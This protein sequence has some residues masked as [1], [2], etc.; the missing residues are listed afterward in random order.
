MNGFRV[1][2][3]YP[4]L[5]QMSLVPPSICLL[6]QILKDHDITVELFDTTYYTIEGFSGDSDVSNQTDL[7]TRPYDAEDIIQLKQSN[8]YEDL[9]CKVKEFDPHLI[10]VSV[11]ESTFMLSISLLREI[12]QYNVLTIAGGVFPTFAPERAIRFPE[13]DIICV[14]EGE[15]SLVDLCER[16]RRGEDYSNVTNLWIKQNDGQVLRNP[17]AK[18]VNIDDNPIPDVG[19]FEKRRH[20]RA[21]AGNIYLMMAIETHR[22]CPFKCGYCNSPAQNRLYRNSTNCNFLRKR[23]MDRIHEEL[24]QY[25]DIWNAEYIFF[26]ADT[27]FTYSDQEI[28]EF[29]EMY[30]DIRLPFY[31]NAHPKT[32][33]DYKVKRLKEAGMHRMGVGIEHGNEKFRRE[34]VNRSYSNQEAI[35]ALKIPKRYDVK[36]SVNNIIGFPDE[37]YELA[38]DT[39]E[40]NR[41]IP[42][43]DH[44]CSIFQPYYGTALRELAVKRGYLDADFIAP[45]NT[46]GSVLT[47]PSFPKDRIQG[48][49]RTFVMYTRFPRSR[50]NEIKMAEQLTSEGDAMWTK[51]RDEFVENYFN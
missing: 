19:I 7:V 10:A 40:L 16:L 36:F 6:S 31:C 46:E 8:V 13:I 3:L 28:D 22:G 14:G 43:S 27:F 35:E 44:S 4:N 25:R 49:R 30:S 42:A 17:M 48:L 50:W 15:Q 11:D 32:I 45:T 26:C 20:Y 21:M 41:H 37:T 2:F 29:C 34:V 51:L 18:P 9:K 33:N 24:V 47:M 38:M 5:R 39:I 1:L 12:R 23:S